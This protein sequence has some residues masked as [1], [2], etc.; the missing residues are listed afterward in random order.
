M[1][2]AYRNVLFVE[3]RDDVNACG[4]LL[5]KHDLPACRHGDTRDEKGNALDLQRVVAVRDLGG[6]AQLRADLPSVLAQ[7]STLQ[8]AGIVID[9]DASVEDRWRSITDGLA[10]SAELDTPAFPDAPPPEGWVGDLVTVEEGRR[11]RAGLWLMPDNA[12]PGALEA[13][14][15]ALV[16]DGDALWPY[17]AAC[18]DGLPEQRFAAKDRGKARIHT[19]LA[20]Q[21][22][23]RE[24]I[25]RALSN[26]SLDAEA[27]PATTFAAWARRLF[28]AAA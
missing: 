25:G 12:S 3:G 28:G 5:A 2:V 26:G 18:L 27:A 17:A 14:A 8:R 21:K 7:S 22:T 13:F 1:S 10:G 9:A 15:A 23:P 6:Y 19:W 20:W 11:I 16:P 4:H 24:P